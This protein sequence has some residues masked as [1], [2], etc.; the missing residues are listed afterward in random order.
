MYIES[1]YIENFGGTRDKSLSF[2]EKVNVIEGKNESGK[3]TLCAFIKFM[4]YGF[5]DKEER[6]RY[7]TWGTASAGG[8]M[9]I[10]VDGKRYRI[11]REYIENTGD[12]VRII[13]LD[14][15]TPV[16][17][18]EKPEDVFLGISGDIFAQTAYIGQTAGGYINGSKVSSSIENILFSADETIDTEKALKKL[19][20]ARIMLQHKRGKGGKLHELAEQRDE[21]I[22]RLETAKASNA[23]IIEKEG[24]LRETLKL[25][26]QNEA[27]LKENKDLLEYYEA[28]KNYRTYRKYKSLSKKAS[29]LEALIGGLK[30]NYT[31]EGFL[32]DGDYI[33][34]LKA[35]EDEIL[36]LEE[37]AAE[38]HKESE[39]QK[40]KN[41]DLFEM[42]VFIDK[43]NENGGID[44]TVRNFKRI[45]KNKGITTAFAVIMLILSIAAGTLTFVTYSK[46][47]EIFMYL[48]VATAAF[49]IISLILFITASRQKINENEFLALLDIDSRKDFDNAVSRFVSDENKLALHNSQIKDLEEKYEKILSKKSEKEN[50]AMTLAMRWGK[51]DP[52]L[53]KEKASEVIKLITDNES[54]A[55]K[56]CVARDAFKEQIAG[57]DADKTKEILDGRDYSEE[58]FDMDKVNEALREQDFYSKSTQMLKQKAT[59]LEKELAVLNATVENPT[60]LGDKVNEITSGISELT[61]KYNAYLLAYEKLTEA[62]ENLRSGVSPKLAGDAGSY[63][64]KLTDGKY[65]TLG[66]GNELDLKYETAGQNRSV[67][68]MSA[69]TRDLAYYSLRLALISLLYKKQLPPVVFDESFSRL[70][71]NRMD[72]M[73]SLVTEI[74]N[75]G[76]QS[77]I[78]TS[79]TRDAVRM[80]N[81]NLSFNHVR[82]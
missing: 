73:L 43:V 81:S 40:N 76:I 42:S 12:K 71:D 75:M 55:E 28:A 8:T 44:E 59:D 61:L 33:D 31:Y 22:R 41:R 26:E 37:S 34:D 46:A 4:F 80:K 57:I 68:H 17:K 47:P 66:I 78:F 16:F 39:Q 15:N 36:H 79:Q 29:E 30:S 21:M 65:T 6:K 18:G 13:D 53:A 62:S 45:R 10:C 1:L 9:T 67:E 27:R 20:E 48:A 35:L 49:L 25:I 77:L 3:S 82:I 32:P 38:L 74:S 58:S 63:L 72:N 7:Y 64:G 14:T 69:G 54:E 2:A 23:G 19:D 56:I 52:K 60:F 5:G 51:S 11:E 50:A 70:D 24:T